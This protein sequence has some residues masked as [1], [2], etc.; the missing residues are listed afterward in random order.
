[1]SDQQTTEAPFRCLCGK[2]LIEI[3]RCPCVGVPREV[4][5]FTS[6]STD[7]SA[8]LGHQAWRRLGFGSDE[9]WRRASMG[10]SP[11]G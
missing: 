10:V 3:A 8:W 2:G 11:N 6:G 9:A 1:M 5:A 4:Q 7:A